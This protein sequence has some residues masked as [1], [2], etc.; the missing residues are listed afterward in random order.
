[1]PLHVSAASLCE[2]G[3]KA[4]LKKPT[5]VVL[6]GQAPKS[7]FLPGCS[8]QYRNGKYPRRQHLR[9]SFFPLL[10]MLEHRNGCTSAN[11][12]G[13]LTQS[14]SG[15]VPRDTSRFTTA[16]GVVVFIHIKSH[17]TSSSRQ[18]ESLDVGAMPFF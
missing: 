18:Q 5:H 13:T 11:A 15:I 7:G 6:K 16:S 10:R 12:R 8:S 4:S 1:M 17:L 9:R 14:V 3:Q 2:I